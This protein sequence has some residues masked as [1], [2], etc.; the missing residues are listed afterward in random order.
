M[1]RLA[2]YAITLAIVAGAIALYLAL[3]DMWKMANDPGYTAAAAHAHTLARERASALTHLTIVMSYCASGLLL[4]AAVAYI[5]VALRVYWLASIAQIQRYAAD[6]MLHTSM[7][8]DT[9]MPRIPLTGILPAE[10]GLHN[11]SLDDVI[12]ELASRTNASGQ[13]LYSRS[14][15]SELLTG[16]KQS[17]LEQLDDILSKENY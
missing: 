11:A 9:D 2:Y 5:Y 15:L 17:R 1:K 3:L 13:P 10:N 7:P 6:G 8:A 16:S 14:R 12:R 4:C